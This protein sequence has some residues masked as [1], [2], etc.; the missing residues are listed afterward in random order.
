[1]TESGDIT[2]SYVCKN[3]QWVEKKSGNSVVAKCFGKV[4][5]IF[6]VLRV[7]F[8]KTKFSF[9]NFQPYAIHLV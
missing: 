7:I 3:D 8:L 5:K 9:P 2:L 1:M 6:N 4:D